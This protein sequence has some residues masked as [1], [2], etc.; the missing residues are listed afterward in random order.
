MLKAEV[1]R[2]KRFKKE[3]ELKQLECLELKEKAND[4]EAK[5]ELV[6]TQL[7]IRNKAMKE[8]EKQLKD[9]VESSE[10]KEM[11]ANN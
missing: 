1:D 11:D 8:I 2:L 10:R 3:F 5:L 4:L 9:E 7:T 6:N